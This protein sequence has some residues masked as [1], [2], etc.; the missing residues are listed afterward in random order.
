[1]HIEMHQIQHLLP[2]KKKK[3]R[4]RKPGQFQVKWHPLHV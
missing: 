1:M 4:E 3:N 2:T